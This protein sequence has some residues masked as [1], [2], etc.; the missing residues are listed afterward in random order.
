MKNTDALDMLGV[1][2]NR[3]NMNKNREQ[4]G[5]ETLNCPSHAGS[6][7]PDGCG[8]SGTPATVMCGWKS[9]EMQRLA[10]GARTG[11]GWPYGVFFFSLSLC[12]TY[13]LP[14]T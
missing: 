9:Q 6:E 1:D 4:E 10:D 13:S 11:G 14:L 12:L 8:R 2:D 5:R 7:S 3:K